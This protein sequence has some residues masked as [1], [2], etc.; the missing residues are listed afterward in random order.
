MKR[1]TL[2]REIDD[3]ESAKFVQRILQGTVGVGDVI[4]RWRIR[5]D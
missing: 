4:E 3:G 2:A 5:H 1:V